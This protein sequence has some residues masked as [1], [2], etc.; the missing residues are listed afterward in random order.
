M[1][2]KSKDIGH[3]VRDFSQSLMYDF[4]I[5]IAGN[6]INY[7]WL[8]TSDGQMIDYNW[9]KIDRKA[10]Q[11]AIIS[12]NIFITIIKFI[13]KKMVLNNIYY[14]TSLAME[15]KK[16]VEPNDA[17]H[18]DFVNQSYTLNELENFFWSLCI[19][20]KHTDKLRT[21]LHFFLW[22]SNYHIYVHFKFYWNIFSTFGLKGKY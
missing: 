17:P 8:S 14:F 11:L 15:N 1:C 12:S 20:N 2:N 10:P 22:I 7:T 3:F 6:L 4:I 19:S 5:S 13:Y 21:N 9:L 18:Q 16:S